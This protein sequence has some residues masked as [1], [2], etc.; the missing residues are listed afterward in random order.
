MKRLLIAVV[1]VAGLLGSVVA[2]AASVTSPASAQATQVVRPLTLVNGHQA[3]PA[4]N[5][6]Q[7][8][9]VTVRTLSGCNNPGGGLA[10]SPLTLTDGSVGATFTLSPGSAVSAGQLSA[11]CNWSITYVNSLGNCRVA[12]APRATSSSANLVSPVTGGITLNG[13]TRVLQYN[14]QQA[15][16]VAFT[17]TSDCASLMT[18]PSVTVTVPDTKVN[19]RNVY[20]G[21]KFDVRISRKTG[22]STGC[23]PDMAVALTIPANTNT[24]TVPIRNLVERPLDAR[25]DCTYEA[26][27]PDEVGSLSVVTTVDSNYDNDIS[28]TNANAGVNPTATATYEKTRAAISIVTEYPEDE[29]FTT[30]DKVDY[31]INVANPCGGY[32]SAIP[33]QFG[34]QG[35]VA[36]TQVFPG[37]ITV[38]DVLQVPVLVNGEQERGQFTIDAYADVAGNMPCTVTVTEKNG[39]ERC[40]SEGGAS[41]EVTYSRGETFSFN[42]THTCDSSATGAAGDQTDTTIDPDAPPTPPSIDLGIGEQPQREIPTG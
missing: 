30:N 12:A 15:E 31:F 27:F 20:A 33:V 17:V 40:A 26:E 25:S 18:G 21:F 16:A 38:Y 24:V 6:V 5:P 2:V 22:P 36:T 34:S 9:V 13:N 37:S 35:R 29:E 1:A 39:P 8:I 10:G 4:A 23:T 41:K 14:G 3:G 28:K 7:T 11:N 32:I 42:F 19:N